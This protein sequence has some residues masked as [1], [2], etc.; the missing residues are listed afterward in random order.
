MD[1]MDLKLPSG[2]VAKIVPYFTRGDDKFITKERWGGATVQ[3]KD[4][5]TV[6]IQNIPVNQADREEDAV[7]LRGTKL[8]DDKEVTVEMLDELESKDFIFLLNELKKV[9]AGKKK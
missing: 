5:G 3:N 8:I 4:D 1:L 2:K 6:E 7:V 9:R